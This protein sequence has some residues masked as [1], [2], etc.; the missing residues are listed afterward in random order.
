MASQLIVQKDK[1]VCSR[2]NGAVPASMGVVQ[3][4]S[5]CPASMGR[6]GPLLGPSCQREQSVKSVLAVLLVRMCGF[7]YVHVYV[8][9]F[10]KEVYCVCDW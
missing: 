3:P 10:N 6:L 4:P 7:S 8:F 2:S 9:H 5:G 1:S